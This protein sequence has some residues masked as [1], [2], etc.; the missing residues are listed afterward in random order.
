LLAPAGVPTEIVQDLNEKV[1]A[2]L[3]QDDVRQAIATIGAEPAAMSPTE[4]NELIIS[5]T[6][7]WADVVRDSNIEL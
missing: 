5:D 1:N 2:L 3:A 6:R 4:F 7:K